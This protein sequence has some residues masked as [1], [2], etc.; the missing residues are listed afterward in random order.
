MVEKLQWK[1]YIVSIPFTP[2]P[3]SKTWGLVLRNGELH[4]RNYGRILKNGKGM[5]F[6][7]ALQEASKMNK[8]I[9]HVEMTRGERVV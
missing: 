5:H 3:F 9:F 1:N 2:P 8:M 4:L 6:L 7:K